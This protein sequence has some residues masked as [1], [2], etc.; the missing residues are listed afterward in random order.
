VTFA[1]GT[2]ADTFGLPNVYAYDAK[3]QEGGY[4]LGAMAARLSSS[5]SIGVIGP[6]EVGDAALYV[7]GFRAGAQA[8]QP[9]A[10]V[11]VAYTGSFSDLGLA[12]EE[13]Q[14]Q[15]DAGADVMTGSAQMVVGAVDVADDLGVLWFGTQA[16]QSSLAP[17]IVVASQVYRWEV[18]L[19]TIL[20]DLDNGQPSG[21][22][23]SIDLANGGLAIEYNDSYSLDPDIRQLG[24]RLVSEIS[25]GAVVPPG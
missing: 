16:N 21:K 13:A 19:R 3:S 20:T 17:D 15:I 9:G 24:D 14:S 10:N 25:S 5:G 1:W 8:E 2:A 18:V 22:A 11:I 12:A 23:L 4:V 6:I 7:G